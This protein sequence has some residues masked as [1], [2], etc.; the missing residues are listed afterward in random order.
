MDSGIRRNDERERFLYS[1]IRL[2]N[3]KIILQLTQKMPNAHATTV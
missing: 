2:L 3:K 1:F